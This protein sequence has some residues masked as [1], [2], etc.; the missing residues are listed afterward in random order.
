MVGNDKSCQRLKRIAMHRKGGSGGG[1]QHDVMSC[2][3]PHPIPVLLCAVCSKLLFKCRNGKSLEHCG[4][5][6]IQIKTRK[7]ER[8]WDKAKGR[9]V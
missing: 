3:E 8:N 5:E 4:K 6:G 2:S 1:K 7:N 9:C